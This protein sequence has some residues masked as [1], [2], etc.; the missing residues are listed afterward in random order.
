MFNGYC[1]DL[2]GEL[3]FIQAL[4]LLNSR[5][6]IVE[7]TRD[8][9]T[10]L[11]KAR[12]KRRRPPLKEFINTTIRLNR[13]QANRLGTPA[14]RDAAGHTSCAATKVRRTAYTLDEPRARQR[15]AHAA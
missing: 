5:N 6:S 4:L 7:Q 14:D 2:N 10:R 9:F 8:D 15:H 13:T 1:D 3:P 12:A 11:N